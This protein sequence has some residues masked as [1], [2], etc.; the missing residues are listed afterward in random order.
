MKHI[1]ILFVFS[2]ILLLFFIYSNACFAFDQPT[3]EKINEEIVSKGY[4]INLDNRLK[5]F[6]NIAGGANQTF[7]KGA[8]K[9]VIDW[10]KLGGVEED[11]PNL[12]RNMHHFHDPLKS[13]DAAGFKELSYSSVVWAQHPHQNYIAFTGDYCWQDTRGYFYKALTATDE[14]TRNANYADC[15]R[16]LGQQMHL[17]QD[18]SVPGHVRNDFHWRYHYE[19]WVRTMQ[20]EAER[21]LNSTFYSFI[22]SSLIKAVKID[23][24]NPNLR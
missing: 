16:G 23:R 6:L 18:A 13:W 11:N 14:N 20:D 22:D 3:H 7:T 1:I 2:C 8:T 21:G 10:I 17:V 5:A 12:I 4:G 24:V 19:S 15:F 9:K